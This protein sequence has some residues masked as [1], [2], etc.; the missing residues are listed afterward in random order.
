MVEIVPP[1]WRDEEKKWQLKHPQYTMKQLA[2][3]SPQIASYFTR[4]SSPEFSI[5]QNNTLMPT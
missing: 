3:I 1:P 2:I 4:P 5:G